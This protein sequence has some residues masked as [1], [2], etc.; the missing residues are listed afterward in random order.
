MSNTIEHIFVRSS[1]SKH[2]HFE[3]SRGNIAGLCPTQSNRIYLDRVDQNIADLGRVGQNIV[4]FHRTQSNTLAESNTVENFGGVGRNIANLCRV[5]QNSHFFIE[6]VE[7]KP[8][9][10]S[11]L[12]YHVY[13]IKQ[14]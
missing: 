7:Y 11:E 2:S 8:N 6:L 12:S 5:A 3:S 9:T 1:W 14:S 4:G 13:F 10:Q